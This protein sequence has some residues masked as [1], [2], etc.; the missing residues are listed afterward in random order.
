[1]YDRNKFSYLLTNYISGIL[2]HLY[3]MDKITIQI[4]KW[5]IIISFD[6]D[7]PN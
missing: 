7:K 1:M 6:T 5:F 2:F 4:W 3:K